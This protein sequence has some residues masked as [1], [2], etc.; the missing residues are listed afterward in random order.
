MMRVERPLALNLGSGYLVIKEYNGYE[1]VNIDIDNANL[2]WAV[3]KGAQFICMDLS[4]N[5]LPFAPSSVS[6]INMS[7]F[8]EHL[9]LRD[10]VALLKDCYRVMTSGGQ[11]RISVPNAELLL[12]DYLK[13]QLDKFASIQ[14][15]EYSHYRS[16]MTKFGLILFGAM[17][18]HGE[19][20]HKMC[21][22][23]A[24]LNEIMLD[25]GFRNVFQSAHDETLDASVARDH[26]MIL[27]ASKP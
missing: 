8:F 1:F 3:Q 22:D 10:G 2:P 14:P 21:Y 9:N 20:G 17:S 18:G 19:L 27:V 26:E 5:Q 13:A 6:F 25:I 16:Q 23:P 24:S 12:D 11:I 7:E 15:T 4:K